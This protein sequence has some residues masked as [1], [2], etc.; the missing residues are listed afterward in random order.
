MSFL[1]IRNAGC[2]DWR[3][4]T[5]LGVSTTRNS[6]HAG[7]IGQF[8]SGSKLS[9]ALLLRH[10]IKPTVITG[11]LRLDFHS[12]EVQIRGQSFEQ[13][14]VSLSGKDIDGTQVRRTDDLGFTLTWGTQDWKH[15]R[16]ALRE[17]VANAIDGSI[18]AGGTFRGVEF[19]IEEKPRAKFGYTSVFIPLT[20]EIQ[21]L[22]NNIGTTFLHYGNPELLDQKFLPKI[23]PEEEDKVLIYKKGVLVSYLKG[24]SVFDYNLGDELELDESRNCNEWHVRYHAAQALRDAEPHT[25]ATI[26]KAVM[27]DPNVWEAQLDGSYLKNNE[28][29]EQEEQNKRKVAFQ[30]AWASVAGPKG[31][32]SSGKLA[33]DSFIEQKGFTPVRVEGSWA[34]ALE[35]YDVP[36]ESRV[37]DK[38]EQEGKCINEPSPEMEQMVQKVWDLFM[39]YNLTNGKEKPKV[40]GFCQI[41]DGGTQCFGYY[42][43]GEDTVYLHNTLGVGEMMYKVALEECVHY[44]TGSG[45]MSRDI[46]DW[47]FSLVTKMAY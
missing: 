20:E 45:D 46:Q 4:F 3:G 5:L 41:M 11:N 9:V 23:K 30:T 43:P 13:V 19:S 34:K 24:K 36:T 14:C 38:S 40:K 29:G 26:L 17:F 10:G 47:L 44:V 18:C 42:L 7:T 16:M 21:K 35:S 28:Y 8:G 37:L 12:K 39:K 22:Y 25:L 33:L 32:V 31:V 1:M 27:T 2:A 6:G 15:L